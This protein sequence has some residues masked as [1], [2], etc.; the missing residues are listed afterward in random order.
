MSGDPRVLGL[1]E[2]MLDSGRT[3]EEVCRGRPDLLPEVRA[4][5]ARFGPIDSELG[6]MFPEPGTPRDA[7]EPPRVPGYEIEAVVG[8]GGMG[9]VYRARH[10]R[11]NRTVAL[12]MLLAGPYAL[13]TERERFVREA[14][15]VAG[16]RHPNIVQVH[17]A[18]EFDGRP[19]F[20]MEL[21]EGGTLA[22]RLDGTPLPAHDAAAL[23]AALAD[24]VG[25][26]HAA[27]IVHRDLKPSN[28]LLAADGTPK[29]SDFGLARRVDGG[30]GLTRTGVAVGTPSY[31]SPCQARGAKTALGPATD[32]YALGAILY[33]CLTGRPPFKAES[34]LETLQQVLTEDPVSPSRLNARV[35]RDPETVC[36]KCLEKD[37]A[38]RY[39]SAAA[40]ADDLRR[41]ERGEPILARPLG[42]AGRLARWA[43]R[44][45]AQ[46]ALLAAAV[47]LALGAAGGGGW[48]IGLRTRTARAVEADLAA[49]VR[50][51]QRSALPEAR[52]TLEQARLRLGDDGP[53]RLRAL[54]DRARHD[55]QLLERLEAV[56]MTRSTF[57]E[58]R[59]NHPA[60]VRFNNARADRE[61]QTAFRDAGLGEPPDDPDGAAGRVMASAVRVPLAAALDDWAVCTPDG[62]RREWVLRVARGADPDG[63][64]DRARD[65]A[66][67]GDAAALA[68]LARTVSVAEQPP[69]LLLAVGERLQLAGGDGVELLRR[70][71]EQYPDDFWVNFT[72]GRVLHEPVRQDGGDWSAAAACY[73]QASD[74][75]PRAVAVQNNY[76]LVLA[77]AGILE[78]GS[79]D[80]GG[81]GAITIFRRAL[82]IEPA[83]APARNNL[84]ICLK[85]KGEWWLAIHEYRDALLDD[86]GSA[87]AHFNLGE[88]QAGSGHID[89]AIGHYRQA[90]RLEP[91]YALAHYFLGIALLAKG[92]ADEVFEDY[93][94][95]DRALNHSRGSA[96]GEANA[97]YWQAYGVDPN[98]AA[99]RN[100]LRIP[101]ADAARLDEAIDHFR[102]ATRHGPGLVRPP[103]ALGLALLAKWQPAEADAALARCL[104]LLPAGE[105]ELRRNVERLRERCRR[106][107]ALEGRLDGITR[108]T[109]EPAADDRLE[110]AELCFVK[111]HYAT[112]ARLYAEAFTAEP[113]LAA[114]LRA[115]HRFNAARAAAL[116]GCGRGDDPAGRG[117]PELTGLRRRACEWLRLDLADCARKMDLGQLRDQV[118]VRR[119]LASW[120]H[121]PDLA[122]V[123]DPGAVRK[124]PPDERRE[125]QALWDTHA[126]RIERFAPH[127]GE[128]LPLP[129]DRS[130]TVVSTRGMF[131]DEKADAERLIFADWSPKEF[132][133][134][135]FRLVDPSGDRVPNVV[136]LHGPMGRLPPTM[137]K[138][139]TIPCGSPARA[140]HFLS[141]VGGWCH[142]FGSRG[143]TSVIVRLHYE[144]GVT[145]D[146]PLRNGE[147]F[148]DYLSR[149]DVP[150]SKFAFA[151]RGQQIR[152]LVIVPSRTDTI[153]EIE[154]VKG[155]DS[156]APIVMAV[157]VEKP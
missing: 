12:K 4:W 31:M 39:P 82:R 27:G 154:L 78:D 93:P 70:V 22:R 37:P 45:P 62:A 136:M 89:E 126:S 122:G 134:V 97:Y 152:Y 68:E 32:V 66:A 142:P 1:L 106:L 81:P 105:T 138:A 141:G 73:K 85:R 146:H 43:R 107:V 69:S 103:G 121:E 49:V 109:D 23:V 119:V 26:A 75:R 94:A 55:Q 104:A 40:L 54:L 80:R 139:V 48:L 150:G 130:A 3:P 90:V 63:W 15:A 34:A 149:V 41:F 76:G 2:E 101:P 20:T 129:L 91:D 143:S 25:A 35:P 79:D 8:C 96:V 112:A 140:I 56:R 19:Y 58:G 132:D 86:P 118:E 16:L 83:F 59:D 11:L 137:P 108:G 38:R 153:R 127:R 151:L 128:W 147:H 30:P 47:L 67:W 120:R 60:D 36:L 51:Q 123:R 99:A 87:P 46:A 71:R 28:V 135:P 125:W 144:G 84:G 155:T 29:V 57:V 100:G 21:V 114:D 5:W 77:G 65:P 111:N 10:L 145:E 17:D 64:R 44:R 113:K 116:A 148:A 50:L 72:L 9:V 92:R 157:T 13:P 53:D 95:G 18:G 61:Y 24:A 115:G 74:I 110:A 7:G 88:I 117:E 102:Q 33:E 156:T 6:A 42:R 14:E 124:L 98:W 52:V 131:Y 133:G